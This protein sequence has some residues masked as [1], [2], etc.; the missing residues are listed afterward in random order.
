M[1][2]RLK[3]RL[4]KIDARKIPKAVFGVIIIAVSFGFV[5]FLRQFDQDKKGK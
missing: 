2:T 5:M 4:F 1:K 3:E